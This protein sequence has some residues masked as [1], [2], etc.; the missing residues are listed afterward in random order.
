M[1]SSAAALMLLGLEERDLDG[2]AWG[3]LRRMLSWRFPELSVEPIDAVFAFS[4]DATPACRNVTDCDFPGPSNELLAATVER[5]CE[6]FE[7]PVEV[8]AQW[9]IAASLLHSG[10]IPPSR[11]HAAGTPGAYENT[12]QILEKMFNASDAQAPARV[13]VLAHP[14][15]LLRAFWTAQTRLATWQG[16]SASTDLVPAMAPYGLGWP[17]AATTGPAL[18]LYSGVEGV[19]HTQGRVEKASWYGESLGFF[20]DGNP[21]KWVHEREVWLLYD[22]WARAKDVSQGIIPFGEGSP[23]GTAS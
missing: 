5:F 10:I 7:R 14:D 2:D 18:N 13:A 17:R 8:Y 6:Q 4:F 11:V 16:A 20:P 9:E 15:H 12:V 22:V 1:L 23:S 19:V 3:A 21:Q